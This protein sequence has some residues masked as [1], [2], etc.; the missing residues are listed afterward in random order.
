VIEATI[1]MKRI[2]KTEAR[3]PKDFMVL[4]TKELLNVVAKAEAETSKQQSKEGQR[5]RN[6][7]PN[8]KDE[9]ERTRENELLSS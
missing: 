2:L 6:I 3:C 7:T 4:S 8:I 1:Y 5:K 9:E